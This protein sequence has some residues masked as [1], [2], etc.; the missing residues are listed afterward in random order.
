MPDT[1]RTFIRSASSFNQFPSARRRTVDTRL[2]LDEARRA[3]ENYN[4]RR[5]PAQVKRG[6][7]MEFTKE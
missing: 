6:A 7:K 2:T 4:G 3:C 1:Y 5:T